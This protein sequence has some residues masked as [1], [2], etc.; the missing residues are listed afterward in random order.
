MGEPEFGF[1]EA[2]PYAINKAGMAQFIIEDCS[3]PVTNALQEAN[4]GIISRIE[5]QC[6]F[7]AMEP[8]YGTFQGFHLGI[9]AR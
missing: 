7:G 3:I 6:G 5:Y 4:I 1:T 2:K 9:I 8:G